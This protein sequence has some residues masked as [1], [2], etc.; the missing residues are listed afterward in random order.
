MKKMNGHIG[1]AALVL[2]GILAAAALLWGCL[3]PLSMDAP[4]GNAAGSVEPGTGEAEGDFTF[5]LRVG[6]AGGEAEPRDIVGPRSGD[7]RFGNIRNIVQVIV[8][9]SFGEVADFQQAIRKNDDEVS[10]TIYIKN[11]FPGQRYHFLV[12]AGYRDRNYDKES[13]GGNYDF[14]TT[15]PTLLAAGFLPDW[16]R[17]SGNTVTIAMK[18]LTVDT[19]FTYKTKDNTVVNLDAKLPSDGDNWLPTDAVD[20]KIV[21]KL[22]AGLSNLLAARNQIIKQPP[23]ITNVGELFLTQK[24]YTEKDDWVDAS[25]NMVDDDMTLTL[26]I[27]PPSDPSIA[28][29]AAFNLTGYVPFGFDIDI[30]NTFK[31]L[32]DDKTEDPLSWIVRNGVN[33]EAQVTETV[34]PNPGGPTNPIWDNTLNGNGGIPYAFVKTVGANPEFIETFAQAVEELP[35]IMGTGATIAEFTLLLDTEEVE[36]GA[37]AIGANGVVLTATG[38]TA[39]TVDLAGGGRTIQLKSGKTVPLITVGQGVT[40]KLRDITFEGLDDNEAPLIK[41]ET[42]GTLILGSGG[43]L[44]PTKVAKLTGNTN[45]AGPG[46]VEVTGGVFTMM[47]NGEI[48]GNTGATGGVSVTAGKFAMTGGKISGNTGTGTDSGGGVLIEDGA[49]F[50]KTGGTIYGTDADPAALANT[51]TGS[52]GATVMDGTYWRDKTAD[53]TVYLNNGNNNFGAWGQN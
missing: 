47:Q 38:S 37:G 40:L 35:K 9:D 26:D 4:A 5:I 52:H 42:G 51:A 48:S 39:F 18:F 44:T 20:P 15:D 1:A 32:S 30:M 14:K 11:L 21:W 3:N 7:I 23:V 31:E 19:V 25:S 45:T 50:T 36:I 12:L 8:V 16:E 53:E 24:T 27:A 33:D 28:P 13:P 17:G 2:G 22:S 43:T 46:G 34:F 6:V 10:T 49:T 41:V 29:V